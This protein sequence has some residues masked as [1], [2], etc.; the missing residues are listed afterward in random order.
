[1]TTLSNTHPAPQHAAAQDFFHHLLHGVSNVFVSL[2]R[3]MRFAR[4]CEAEFNRHGQVS[5]EA[6][7]RLIAEV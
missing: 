4:Q 7:K 2:S 6:M 3:A 1:M 5:S